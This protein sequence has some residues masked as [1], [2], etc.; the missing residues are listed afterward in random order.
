M[1][2]L[3]ESYIVYLNES[4]KPVLDFAKMR[5]SIEL[6]GQK[7][8]EQL[9]DV[10]PEIDTAEL[11]RIALSKFGEEFKKDHD[12][13]RSK[14]KSPEIALLLSCLKQVSKDVP[15]GNK[16]L[17]FISN[18]L[19]SAG[20]VALT[21]GLLGICIFGTIKLIEPILKIRFANVK[22]MMM[23]S[24]LFILVGIILCIVAK[25]IRWLDKIT[26]PDEDSKKMAKNMD[27][28]NF[29]ENKKTKKLKGK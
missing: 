2:T 11:Y 24:S 5:K 12:Q 23:G 20:G 13:Y 22:E 16:I 19:E 14:T 27:K 4:E 7:K 6:I 10:I 29:T 8:I 15:F 25:L 17:K 3:F 9:K 26:L 21:S 1:P 28:R 18:V